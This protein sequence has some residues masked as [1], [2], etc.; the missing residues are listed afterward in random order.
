MFKQLRVL[1]TENHVL[2]FD[3]GGHRTAYDRDLNGKSVKVL[4]FPKTQFHRFHKFFCGNSDVL[5]LAN[6]TINGFGSTGDALHLVTATGGGKR[7]G[8]E[9]R[10]LIMHAS[11]AIDAIGLGGS[12]IS[13]HKTVAFGRFGAQ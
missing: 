1:W 6:M 5:N 11:E 12:Q 10:V 8:A 9:I 3:G 4:G 7:K 13:E 2:V